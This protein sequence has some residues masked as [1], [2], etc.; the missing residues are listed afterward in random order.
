MTTAPSGARLV[1]L[2]VGSPRYAAHHMPTFP[3]GPRGEAAACQCLWKIGSNL[4][5]LRFP[6]VDA[7]GFPCGKRSRMAGVDVDTTDERVLADALDR[8]G[9]TPFIVRTASGKWHGCDRHETAR[10]ADPPCRARAD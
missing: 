10:A 6:D 7:F 1:C 8:H 9:P 4:N 3:V 5:T 2:P